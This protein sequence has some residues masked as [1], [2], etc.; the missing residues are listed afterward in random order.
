M[1]V[2][3][4]D[5]PLYAF[6]ALFRLPEGHTCFD[7]LVVRQQ[8]ACD[9]VCHSYIIHRKLSVLEF[10]RD[11]WISACR[12]TRLCSNSCSSFYLL[13]C[14]HLPREVRSSRFH[15]HRIADCVLRSRRITY[16]PQR[17]LS[18]LCT[19]GMPVVEYY[20]KDASL[21]LANSVVLPL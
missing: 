5:D 3:F 1:V 20:M 4:D 2:S 8:T 13:G 16:T 9:R 10:P 17:A 14:V 15:V 19:R 11:L 21:A 18:P 7:M 12:I 6:V